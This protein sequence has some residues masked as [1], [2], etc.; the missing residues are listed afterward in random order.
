MKDDADRAPR[1]ARTLPK[2]L[3]EL[4]IARSGERRRG[5]EDDES[6]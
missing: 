3:I 2:G 5:A 6:E 4:L 1:R